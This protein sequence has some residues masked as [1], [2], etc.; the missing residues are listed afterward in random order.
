MAIRGT[1]SK[2]FNEERVKEYQYE[3]NVIGPRG[4]VKSQL[5]KEDPAHSYDQSGG[6]GKFE[7]LDFGKGFGT[8]GES[9]CFAPRNIFF[10]KKL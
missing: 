2:I 5:P 4:N 1:E 7:A 10:G 9:V 6:E 8:L 3:L